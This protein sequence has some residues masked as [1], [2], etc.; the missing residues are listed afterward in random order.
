MPEEPVH[1][2]HDKLSRATFSDPRNAA[3]FLRHHLGGALLALV[4]WH[5]LALLPGSLIDSRMAGSEADLLFSATVDGAEAL[6]YI[7]WEHQ[8]TEA[9]LMGLRLLS[10]GVRIWKRQA[11]ERGPSAKLSP[12]LPLVLAQDKD[13]WTSVILES[14]WTWTLIVSGEPIS[15]SF[16]SATQR[17]RI[18][19]ALLLHGMPWLTLIGSPLPVCP[20]STV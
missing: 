10:N 13:H 2:P 1:Q 12:I 16:S 14:R 17:V 4:D 20:S 9:S 18:S 19:A 6:L 8:R 3:A 15:Q 11:V 5:S 7:L